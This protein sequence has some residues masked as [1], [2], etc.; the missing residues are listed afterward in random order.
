M[1]ANLPAG[2]PPP[3]DPGQIEIKQYPRYRAVTYTHTGAPQVAT[4]AAF[5]PLYRHISRN[6]IAMTTPVEARYS[7]N[8]VDVSFL[9][10]DP[11]IEPDAVDPNVSVTDYPAATVASLGIQGAY[12]WERYET[13]LQ[14]LRDWLAQRCDYRAVGS[15]RRLLYNSPMT[16]EAMKRSEVQI[17][18]E[19]IDTLA[20]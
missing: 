1:A 19:P 2:F 9:Y 7:D 10:G 14:Q 13:H 5:D 6:Q 12:T 3:T 4:R 8:A 18:V 16:P 20:S 11:T 15:P 17:P